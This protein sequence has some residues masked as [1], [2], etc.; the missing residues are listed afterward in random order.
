MDHALDSEL[1][2]RSSSP[3]DFRQTFLAF[4]RL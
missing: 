2:P 4:V 3:P 1:C